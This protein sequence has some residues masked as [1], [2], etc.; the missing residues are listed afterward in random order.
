MAKCL[1]HAIKIFVFPPLLAL[2]FSFIRNGDK[3][4]REAALL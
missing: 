3:L 4:G 1:K 2:P